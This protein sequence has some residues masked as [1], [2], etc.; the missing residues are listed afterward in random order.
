MLLLHLGAT[1]ALTVLAYRLLARR[2][3]GA[4]LLAERPGPGSAA[5]GLAGPFS[6]A[7]RLDRGAL[8]L[9]TVGLCLYG[10]MIGS[11]VHGIG[12]EIGDSGV[13]RDIVARLGGTAAMEQAFI[14]VAFSMLAMVASAF[15]ISLTLRLHQEETAGR[16]ETV[17]AG[18]V[19]RTRW[20]ASHLVIAIAGSGVAMLLA[21]LVT[22]LTYGMA[23]GDIGGEAAHRAGYRR[24]A[25]AGGLA[26][27]GGHPRVVR[28]GAA[29][30]PGG[31]GCAG[32]VH[33]AVH[34]RVAGRIPA[35]AAQ[36]LQPFTHIPHVGTGSFTAVPL[37][38]LLAIDIVLIM[39][40]VIAFRR[41]D[42]R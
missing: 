8:L 4:G 18:A 13:A 32:R 17:L 34:A 22:G 23:A 39:L 7:W 27:R 42:L 15:V 19:D 21:G 41:R 3:V 5:P 40:G 11:V 6:L 26:A 12:D 25:V 35:V 36:N 2:D 1:A 14:A 24:G 29:I 28:T 37:L 38:W 33:R 31:V 20:L 10:L 9:W 30:H 16:A